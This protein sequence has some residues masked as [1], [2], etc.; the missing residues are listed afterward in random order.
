MT[1]SDTNQIVER[2]Q[3]ELNRLMA[4][5]RD[6]ARSA[7]ELVTGSIENFQQ[8]LEDLVEWVSEEVDRVRSQADE[9]RSRMEAQFNEAI[10]SLS[11]PVKRAADQGRKA[12]ERAKDRAGEEKQEAAHRSVSSAVYLARIVN[13]CG[14]EC[15]RRA[16]VGLS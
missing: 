15:Q 11:A 16:G 3:A 6:G 14:P 9:Q 2:A 4:E 12:A 13:A 5:A 10:E 7:E 1:V 8:L